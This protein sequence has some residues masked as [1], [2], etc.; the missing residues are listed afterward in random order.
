MKVSVIST[1]VIPAMSP[2]N[3]NNHYNG[4]ETIAWLHANGL[5]R[6]GHEVLFV[7]PIGSEIPPGCQHHGITL[8]EPERQAYSGYW[9]RLLEQNLVLDHSWEKN[10]YLLRMENRL[11]VPILGVLHAPCDTMYQRPPPV[12]FPC[13]VAISKDQADHA[14]QIW[15]I[16]TRVL[17]HGF[18]DSFYTFPNGAAR[19]DR[20]L[21]L[22]RITKLKGAHIAVD[23]C[24]RARVAL[25]IVGDDR[26]TGEPDMA[27]RLSSQCDGVQMKYV[28][29]VSKTDTIK[30]YSTHKAMLHMVRH[31]REPFG[32]SPVEAMLAGCPVI[33]WDHGAMR[34]TVS[35]GVS[36][37]L[38]KSEEEA[39]N[40]IKTNAVD[41]IDRAK[42]R[43]W[44]KQFS[45]PRMIDGL[46]N[47]MNEALQTGGW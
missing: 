36:G 38:V 37:F 31:F 5:A 29:P 33:A 34:E 11:Q 16:P 21:F 32:M 23:L 45:I 8:Y 7:C 41:S 15:G 47:L 44:A 40:L 12:K 28:G 1:T 14:S 22:G 26:L 42:C 27:Q 13:F 17:Y 24:R 4:L 6:R 18:D 46:E 20:Y 35:H 39:L 25:S 43:E 19:E 30:Y 2:Q 10:S 9:Q 3:P